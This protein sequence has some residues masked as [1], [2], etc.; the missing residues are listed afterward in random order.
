[1]RASNFDRAKTKGTPFEVAVTPDRPEARLRLD[2]EP[3]REVL[4]VVP[5]A[6]HLNPNPN[7]SPNAMG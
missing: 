7:P 4:A 5:E 6:D 1:M 3:F 2:S